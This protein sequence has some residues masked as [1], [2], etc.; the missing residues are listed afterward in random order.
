MSILSKFSFVVLHW[1]NSQSNTV[2]FTANVHKQMEAS[3]PPPANS[4]ITDVEG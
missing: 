4:I 3:F 2:L 1:V